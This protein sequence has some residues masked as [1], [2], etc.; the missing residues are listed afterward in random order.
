LNVSTEFPEVIR[1]RKK[2]TEKRGSISGRDEMFLLETVRTISGPHK[3][4]Y[5]TYISKFFQGSEAAG[6]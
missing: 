6:A 5:L 3:S 1:I 2:K 4:S